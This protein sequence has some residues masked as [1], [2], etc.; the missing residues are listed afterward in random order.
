[1]R[2]PAAVVIAQILIAI[3]LLPVAFGGLLAGLG[4]ASALGPRSLITPGLLLVVAIAGFLA[5]SFVALWRRFA[6]AQYLGAL[7]V[8]LSVVLSA[9]S[10]PSRALWSAFL[11]GATSTSTQAPSTGIPY[12]DYNNRNEIVGA[13]VASLCF[14]ASLLVVAAL[15]VFS[16]RVR[17]FFRQPLDLS[18]LNPEIAAQS[19]TCPKCGADSPNTSYQCGKCGYSIV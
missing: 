7:V 9:V 6:N 5:F 10:A 2:R 11:R 8:A 16:R 1:M 13:I 19:W 4:L 18:K 12:F 14:S 17:L 15:L 3:E